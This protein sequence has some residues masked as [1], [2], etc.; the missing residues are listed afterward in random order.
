PIGCW[1]V[2][3]RNFRLF[4][5]FCWSV[6]TLIFFYFRNLTACFCDKPCRVN[7]E[8]CAKTGPTR[9]WKRFRIGAKKLRPKG[10]G[11]LPV[12]CRRPALLRPARAGR[13]LLH[14]WALS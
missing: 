8:V 13:R 14:H 12:P 3:R 10:R 2:S 5:L 4:M 6:L 1:I 7:S 11:A 9:L